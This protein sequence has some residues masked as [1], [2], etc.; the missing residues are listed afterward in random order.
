MMSEVTV[1]I[2]G[3][4]ELERN[5]LALGERAGKATLR[6][7][8]KKALIPVRDA[9]R[10]LAPVDTGDLRDSIVIST[11]LSNRARADARAEGPSSVN[12]YVGTS[13]PNGVPR[14]FGTSRSAADP[15]LRPA[16]DQT[17]DGVLSFIV[18][19]LEREIV[20]TAGRQA[21]RAARAAAAAGG[22]E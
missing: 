15:F 22:G 4:R 2:E 16:W 20:K 18:R 17:S 13:N 11:V 9:A 12:V 1:R 19:E 14:E 10:A 6:R 3:L 21:T 5:L 7:V 8:G